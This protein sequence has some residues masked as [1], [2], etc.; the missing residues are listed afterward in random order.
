MKK[1]VNDDNNN[2][3]DDT[4]RLYVSSKK[5][6]RGLAS[7]EDSVEAS[8]EDSRTI[9]KRIKKYYGSDRMLRRNT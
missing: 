8:I 9:L 2:L 5:G 4:E 6:G 1:I 3:S 7:S